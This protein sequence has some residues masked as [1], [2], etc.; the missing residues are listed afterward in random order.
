MSCIGTAFTGSADAA[1]PGDDTACG[2]DMGDDGPAADTLKTGR[3]PAVRRAAV[4]AILDSRF[5][6]RGVFHH[7]GMEQRNG[8][9][10]D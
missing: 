1:H 10:A 8:A 4:R 5:L 3:Q 9:R 6:L 2:G 7:L